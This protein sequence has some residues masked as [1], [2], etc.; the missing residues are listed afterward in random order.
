MPRGRSADPRRCSLISPATPTVIPI[1]NSRLVA[2][3]QNG[4]TFKWKHDRIEGP[5]RYK[6]MTLPTDE[7]IWWFLM[8]VLPKGLHRIRHDGLFASADR[9]AN[10]ETRPRIARR[11][12]SARIPRHS[13]PQRPMSSKSCH[14]RA[15]AV[16]AA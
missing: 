15:L 16:V 9:A 5:A 14:V 8:H 4:V 10:I 2:C 11:T 12:V 13:M 3:S 6:S 7:F 1:A